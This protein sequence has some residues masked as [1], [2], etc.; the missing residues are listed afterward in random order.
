MAFKLPSSYKKLSDVPGTREYN[1]KHSYIPGRFGGFIHVPGQVGTYSEWMEPGAQERHALVQGQMQAAKDQWRALSMP[2][3][4]AAER[5]YQEG[6]P[7]GAILAPGTGHAV[8]GVTTRTASMAPTRLV[9][10]SAKSYGSASSGIA[11]GGTALARGG[12]AIG[13]FPGAGLS[14]GGVASAGPLDKIGSGLTDT[15]KTV[16][17]TAMSYIPLAIKVGAAIVA[18]KIILWL[19]R[20]K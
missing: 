15:G 16:I 12:P 4:V 14:L 7:I 3:M 11:A 8:S 20:R 6:L 17:D 19:V 2:G 18:I 1:I 13:G 5:A 10:S 9:V